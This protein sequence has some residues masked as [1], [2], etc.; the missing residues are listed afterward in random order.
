MAAPEQQ[1]PAS[2]Q[3]DEEGALLH[4]P[5]SSRSTQQGAP[6]SADRP[7]P[8]A[9]VQGPGQLQAGLS[10]RGSLAASSG[11][12]EG[13]VQA[14][15]ADSPAPRLARAPAAAALPSRRCPGAW[16]GRVL[17]M[18]CELRGACSE[19]QH[20]VYSHLSQHSTDLLSASFVYLQATGGA[21]GIERNDRQ[22]LPLLRIPILPPPQPDPAPPAQ[23]MGAAPDGEPQRRPQR[24]PQRWLH[25]RQQHLQQQRLD[26][27]CH[28]LHSRGPPRS[29]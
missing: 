20:S 14:R 13:D 15:L 24:W 27:Q 6:G 12:R 25:L 2:P 3:Q 16:V 26:I 10:A 28:I 17:Q 7:A 21:G 1:H 22:P 18:S 4:S 19:T 8:P 5:G 23:P 11:K 29:S 9:S